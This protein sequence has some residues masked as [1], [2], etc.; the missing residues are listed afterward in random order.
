M[1]TSSTSL[2]E[3]DRQNTLTEGTFSIEA[4]SKAFKILHSGLYSDK[5]MAVVR[6]LCCNAYDS[7]V[8][9]NKADVAF[10]VHLPNK[11]EPWFSVKDYGVGLT[12]EQVNNLYTSYFKSTKTQ[13]NDFIGALGLGSKSPFAYNDSFSVSATHSGVVRNYT[14]FINEQEVPSIVKLGETPTDECNGVEVKIPVN[15]NDFYTFKDKCLTFFTRWRTPVNVVGDQ[16]FKTNPIESIFSGNGWAIL[17][18]NYPYSNAVMG[19]VAYPINRSAIKNCPEKI[20][21]FLGN[22]NLDLYFEIGELEPAASREALSY[23]PKTCQ[24]IIDKCEIALKEI[25]EYVSAQISSCKT[26]WEAKVK[27]NQIFG[28]QGP[29]YN[30]DR[31]KDMFPVQFN[32]NLIT[33]GSFELNIN[34]LPMNVYDI[35]H[36]GNL[37]STRKNS[38]YITAKQEV[39][40]WLVDLKTNWIAR[41]KNYNESNKFTNI[42]IKLEKQ[43]DLSKLKLLLG[44]AKIGKISSLP[45]PAVEKPVGKIKI[46][47][48]SGYIREWVD[49]TNPPLGGYFLPLV[50]NRVYSLAKENQKPVNV[51]DLGLVL[52]QLGIIGPQEKIY[53]IKNCDIKKYKKTGAW[54][55]L[56]DLGIDFINDSIKKYGIDNVVGNRAAINNFCQNSDMR[57]NKPWKSNEVL[58][59]LNPNSDLYQLFMEIKTAED[60]K[61]DPIVSKVERLAEIMGYDIPI[62]DQDKF[63]R[64]FQNIMSKYPMFNMADRSYGYWN[65][66][67]VKIL[68][69]YFNMVD[70]SK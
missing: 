40:F 42:V 22:A 48:T 55:N 29:F 30:F 60:V 46:W 13:S 64:K 63:S 47:K 31:R 6:E 24:A 67:N 49:E 59:N 3:I 25:A 26:L 35:N 32:G 57:Y 37:S 62:T 8:Q 17:K 36:N 9:A 1:K 41:I 70:K 2:I 44:G 69:D 68:N 39:K 52:A 43:K 28:Y 10:T 14:C 18:G 58:S 56:M 11:F 27:Y 65:R 45:L 23:D 19:N 16:N 38:R 53:G 5:I 51:I 7:H 12:D 15:G 50:R 33:D 61:V 66:D 21:F 4:N 54:F 34:K 20:A